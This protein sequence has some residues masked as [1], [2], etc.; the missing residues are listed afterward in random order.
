M[1]DCILFIPNSN[2]LPATANAAPLLKLGLQG[3]LA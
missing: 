3:L 2:Y 1:T